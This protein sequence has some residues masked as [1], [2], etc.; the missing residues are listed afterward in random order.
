MDGGH[1][2]IAARQTEDVAEWYALVTMRAATFLH[3]SRGCGGTRASAASTIAEGRVFF[4][5][6]FK[7]FTL[8]KR[9]DVVFPKR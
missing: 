1:R 9:G 4:G 3:V 5:G 8:G 2:A 7:Q 6:N